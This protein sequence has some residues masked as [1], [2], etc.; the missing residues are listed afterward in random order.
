MVMTI[1]GA[2]ASASLKQSTL[3]SNNIIGIFINRYTFLGVFLYLVS[4]ILNIWVLKTL[5]YTVVLPLT[6]ITYIWTFI[7]S[8]KIYNERITVNKML[9]CFCLILGAL[10][11]GLS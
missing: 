9:G 3:N 1:V 5:P 7:I 2:L 10:F 6:S 11:V 4:A 8:Y